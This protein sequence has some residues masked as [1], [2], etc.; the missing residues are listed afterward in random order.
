MLRSVRP[1][2]VVAVAMLHAGMTLG[3]AGLHALPGFGHGSGLD[4][5]A[6]NDHSHGPGKSSHQ[7]A[8]ECGVC[9]FLSQGQANPA[10]SSVLSLHP[11]EI[12]RLDLDHVSPFVPPR[13][14]AV[15]RGPPAFRTAQGV[16]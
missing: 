10:T 5:F 3:A 12:A 14:P 8:D 15:P 11:V 9:H 4:H 16:A 2:L 7:S 1:V 13:C 6:R